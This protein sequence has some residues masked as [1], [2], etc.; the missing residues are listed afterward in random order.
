MIPIINIITIITG[1]NR[2]DLFH[3]EEN[4]RMYF[5]SAMMSACAAV[6]HD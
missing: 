2:T 6:D 3:R 5:P 1:R 4:E